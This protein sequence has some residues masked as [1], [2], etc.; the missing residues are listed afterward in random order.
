MALL[1]KVNNLIIRRPAILVYKY[2]KQFS[3]DY[4]DALIET[5]KKW[6]NIQ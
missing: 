2:L 4:R 3:F 1:V 5:G 6:F